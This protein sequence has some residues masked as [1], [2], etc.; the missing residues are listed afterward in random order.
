M[1]RRLGHTSVQRGK[2]VM[3]FFHDGRKEVTKF[4]EKKGRHIVTEL[5]RFPT[6][7]VYKISI[8]R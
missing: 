5:G 6:S 4:I 8:L 7:E 2:K 1:K 3:L